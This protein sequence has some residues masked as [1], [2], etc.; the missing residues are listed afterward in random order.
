MRRFIATVLLT[1]TVAPHV[2]GLSAEESLEQSARTYSIGYRGT[3]SLA[4][5]SEW[6]EFKVGP[7]SFEVARFLIPHDKGT[8]RFEAVQHPGWETDFVLSD[9]NRGI[10]TAKSIAKER[11]QD[12]KV[13]LTKIRGVGNHGSFLQYV[14]AE[15]D[16]PD[17]GYRVQGAVVVDGLSLNFVADLYGNDSAVLETILRVVTRATTEPLTQFELRSPGSQSAILVSTEGF[18]IDRH[19]TSTKLR[20]FALDPDVLVTAFVEPNH[21]SPTAEDCREI[22]VAKLSQSP[23]E[24]TDQ[25]QTRYR[26]MALYEYTIKEHEGVRLMQ[27]HIHAYLGHANACVEVHVSKTGFRESQK[28]ELIEVLNGVRIAAGSAGS[29]EL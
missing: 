2:R 4:V 3:L 5:P 29:G 10:K 23:V 8:V 22:Y 24:V 12:K 16:D 14:V 1:L 6:I 17:H 11:A 9:L 19:S 20:M 21:S 13:N 26:E 25:A 15:P 18:V 27:K 7:N 28:P